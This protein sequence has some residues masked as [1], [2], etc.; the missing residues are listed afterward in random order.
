M[1]GAWAGCALV[2]AAISHSVLWLL[3]LLPALPSLY[4]LGGRIARGYPTTDVEAAQ[5]F[6]QILFEVGGEQELAVIVQDQTAS[7]CE[8]RRG[9]HP[10]LIAALGFVKASSDD[11]LRGVG[12]LQYASLRTPQM[13][14]RLRLVKAIS[15]LAT[16]AAAA[17]AVV[18]APRAAAPFAALASLALTQWLTGALLAAWS[19]LDAGGSVFV[20][21]D[22]MAVELVGSATPVI[23]ALVAM[24]A[25][26]EANRAAQSLVEKAVYRCAQPVLP[27]AHTTVRV[28]RLRA[29]AE[30]T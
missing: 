20:G 26:R 1:W 25:W 10:T 18:I 12:A 15:L 3:L 8:L 17:L 16:V 5:R 24:D 7:P 21:M 27:S 11:V 22:A 2:T 29:L 9:D 6:K 4:V 13:N 28:T 19:T 14:N 23:D 30:A